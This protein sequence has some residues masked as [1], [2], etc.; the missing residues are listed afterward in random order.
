MEEYLVPTQFGEDEFYEKKSQFIGRVWP[1]ETEEEALSKI[2]EM[3]SS[4]TMP[5]ITVGLILSGMARSGSL[6]TEN[7]AGR[8]VCPCCRCCRE[9]G[10]IILSV[11]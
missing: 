11:W 6:T 9:R 3:K 10:F 2:Q 4:I 8:R 7:L 1:V 5:L